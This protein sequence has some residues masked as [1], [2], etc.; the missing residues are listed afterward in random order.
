MFQC[1]MHV[2]MC[3]QLRKDTQAL[4]IYNDN[5]NVSTASSSNENVQHTFDNF[6]RAH[7]QVQRVFISECSI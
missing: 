1:V 3:V 4:A 6:D 5:A 2:I 7:W